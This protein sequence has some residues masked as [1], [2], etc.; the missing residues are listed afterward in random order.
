MH[1]YWL[2]NPEP[3]TDGLVWI[4]GA[5]E[6]G[7]YAYA[8]Q[9][10]PLPGYATDADWVVNTNMYA[11]DVEDDL[12]D[13]IRNTLM[14]NV[15]IPD[16]AN[17]SQTRGQEFTLYVPPNSRNLMFRTEGG[18]GDVALTAR[19]GSKPVA[20]VYDCTSNTG[21]TFQTCAV[22]NPPPAGIYYVKAA[23][24]YSGVSITGSYD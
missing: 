24:K 16:N 2:F 9:N 23:G 4:A 15:S 7:T 3:R 21:G 8:V 11:G 22:P 5:D 17:T 19:L 6:R 13:L 20:L 10:S 1:A 12:W 14:R 18:S